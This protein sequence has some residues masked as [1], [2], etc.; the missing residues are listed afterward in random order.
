MTPREQRFLPLFGE[1]A[2]R[3]RKRV[4][5][6]WCVDET[7]CDFRGTH[8]LRGGFSTLPQRVPPNLSLATAWPQLT[9]VL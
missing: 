9:Q 8:N 2:R 1:A 4:G 5:K 3:H 6:K 7:T